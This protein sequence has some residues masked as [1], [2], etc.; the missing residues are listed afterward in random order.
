M[1]RDPFFEREDKKFFEEWL[2]RAKTGSAVAIGMVAECF[3]TGRG[4]YKNIDEAVKWY[5]LAAE[6]GDLSA[7]A[8]LNEMFAKGET[9][10]VFIPEPSDLPKK[11]SAPF[12]RGNKKSSNKPRKKVYDGNFGE[13]DA[14]LSAL[15]NDEKAGYEEKTF[16]FKETYGKEKKSR[17]H[18]SDDDYDFDDDD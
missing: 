10:E 11:K 12:F 14:G 3:Y 4:T 1:S 2:E 5:K 6:G 16:I 9:S 8:R 15:F 13:V 18:E 17:L 7:Q